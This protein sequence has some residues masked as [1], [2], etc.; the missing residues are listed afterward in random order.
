MV[1]VTMKPTLQTATMMVGTVGFYIQVVI[2]MDWLV[3]GFVM[4]R[5]TLQTAVMMVE[6]VVDMIPSMTI[7]QIAAASLFISI[8]A[9]V[10]PS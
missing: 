5:P 1:Y 4:M 9:A 3:M 8:K 6:T 7:A 10:Y 2:M